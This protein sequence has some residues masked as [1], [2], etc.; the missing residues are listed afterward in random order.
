M[1]YV[2]RIIIF[3]L[4]GI[5]IVATV[6]LL[7]GYK[8]YSTVITKE[9][10]SD[11]ISKIQ[12][13]EDFLSTEELPKQ[14]LDAVVAVEDH[15][16]YNHGPIDPIALLR[17]ITVNIRS[18]EFSE[19]GSTITQQV[20]KN[21][22]FISEKDVVSRK[23]AE[24][25]MAYELEKNYSKQDILELYV[26]TIYFGDGY[27]GINDACNGYF[28]KDAKDMDLYEA[29]MLAGIPNAPSVYAPTKNFDLTTSRQQKVLKSMVEHEYISQ[30][31][32]DNA[33]SSTTYTE[34]SFKKET[35][36][37]KTSN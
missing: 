17:A 11:K 4:I 20:A 12:N 33:I 34:E 16:Y 9:S 10:L 35:K 8:L 15:R 31:D 28:D 5:I 32:A 19:G 23:I 25:I 22:Y 6:V 21:L 13:S 37:N 1:K 2:R 36:S 14:Y 27:Y 29:S 7:N 30:E 3:L 18:Q 26:N 24:V